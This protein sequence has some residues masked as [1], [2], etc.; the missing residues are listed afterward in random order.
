MYT[1]YGDFVCKEDTKEDNKEHF[2]TLPSGS[3][4]QTCTSCFTNDDNLLDCECKNHINRYINTKL[5][6][7]W[8][9]MNNPDLRNINGKLTCNELPFPGGTY[10]NS[11]KKCELSNNNNTLNCR[12]KRLNQ[13]WKNTTLNNCTKNN[14]ENNN[15]DLKC[16]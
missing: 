15:G 4:S 7:Y 14:I 3:Y 12:C 6:L 8:C 9:N 1:A 16:K 5:D 11:C 10:K 13:N 2:N